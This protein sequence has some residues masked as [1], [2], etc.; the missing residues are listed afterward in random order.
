FV[1]GFVFALIFKKNLAKPKKYKWEEED[2]NEAEDEFMKHFDENGNFIE[3]LPEDPLE[4]SAD[5]I[6]ITYTFREKKD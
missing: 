2:Y 3:K 4:N 5:Q 1:T 6:K